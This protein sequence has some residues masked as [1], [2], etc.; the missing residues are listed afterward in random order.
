MVM[1]AASAVSLNF[2]YDALGLKNKDKKHFYLQDERAFKQGNICK[3][4][5][6]EIFDDFVMFQMT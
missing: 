4:V 3:K 6:F 5:S 2:P 1:S